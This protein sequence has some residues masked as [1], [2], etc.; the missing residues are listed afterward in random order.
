[1][2]NRG[3]SVKRWE[4]LDTAAIPRDGGELRLLGGNDEFVIQISGKTGDLMNSRTHGSEDAL[5]TL[6]CARCR[7]SDSAKVLIGGLGMGF[8]LAAAL[9]KL[10][11]NAM[12][13][14]AELV[15]GVVKWNRE[16]LGMCAG[17]PLSDKR[18]E[19]TVSDV[20]ELINGASDE[21]DAIL[22]DVDNGPEGLTHPENDDLYSLQGLGRAYKSLRKSGVLAVWSATPAPRFTALLK[23]AGF[24]VEEKRVRAHKGKGAQNVIWLAS[25]D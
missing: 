25:R 3:I 23:K 15:P 20:A 9:D 24:T 8:T 12:V 21:Y 18:V 13:V 2:T 14:V 19:I 17:D 5:G 11:D 1:M 22:L 6:A 10:A 16:I 4:L 7:R